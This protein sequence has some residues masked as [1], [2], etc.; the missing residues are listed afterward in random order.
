MTPALQS[1][2]DSIIGATPGDLRALLNRY[3]MSGGE[4]PSLY[5]IID[6]IN[7]EIK[8]RNGGSVGLAGFR[9]R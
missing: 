1:Q 4:F 9:V 2:L 8:M 3:E 5:I 7:K 6:D